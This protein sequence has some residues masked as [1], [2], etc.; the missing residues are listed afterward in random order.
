MMATAPEISADQGIFTIA[1]KKQGIAQMIWR[2]TPLL[3]EKN[4]KLPLI[5]NTQTNKQQIDRREITLHNSSLATGSDK[6]FVWRN[7]KKKRQ[8]SAKANKD[9]VIIK[10]EYLFIQL[11]SYK[12]LQKDTTKRSKSFAFLEIEILASINLF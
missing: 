4:I 2:H 6:I 11:L 1:T 5:Y 9:T 8:N 10:F 7:S 12:F 3:T